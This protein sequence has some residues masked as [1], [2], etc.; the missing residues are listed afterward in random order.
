[1][2]KIS[3]AIEKHTLGQLQDLKAQ[4]QAYDEKMERWRV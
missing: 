2:E 4:I 1:M 3:S